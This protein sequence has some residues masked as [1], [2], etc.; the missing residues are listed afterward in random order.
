MHRL[1]CFIVAFTLT[2]NVYSQEESATSPNDN[3]NPELLAMIDQGNKL[4]TNKQFGKAIPIWE[5][6]VQKD[7]EN[8]NANFKLGLCYRNSL[9]GQVKALD[10]FRKAS[11]KMTKKYHFS[12]KGERNAPYD[13][14]YFLGETYLEAN[15]PDS[16]LKYFINYQDQFEDDSPI[17]VNRQMI[18]CINAIKA[19]NEPRDVTV[20]DMG[21]VVNTTAAESFPVVTIDNSVLFFSSRREREDKSN[22]NTYE[23][24]T[25][26]H[27]EDIYIATRKGKR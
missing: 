24:E 2:I 7:P 19:K 14:L 9:D 5:E 22:A 17:N 16:A 15:E 21:E 20:K 6:V 4:L 3:S 23:D 8:S 13:A 25:G 27:F 1:I 26:T 11:M 12:G 10:Y 18:M